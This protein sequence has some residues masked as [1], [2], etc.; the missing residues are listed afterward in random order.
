M[1]YAPHRPSHE[2]RR[3]VA[4]SGCPLRPTPRPASRPAPV[5][6][7]GIT[8]DIS[9]DITAG[10]ACRVSP[11]ASTGGSP[12]VSPEVSR[13]V[14]LGMGRSLFSGITRGVARCRRAVPVCA[15]FAFLL[16]GLL[17]GMVAGPF[18]GMA[19]DALAA[20][21]QGTAPGGPASEQ[22][23]S[24]SGRGDLFTPL[25]PGGGGGMCG[26]SMSPYGQG[27]VVVD[28][29]PTRLIEGAVKNTNYKIVHRLTAPDDQEI[30]A[31]CM[32]LRDD[33]KYIIPALE[34]GNAIIC[35]DEDDAAAW[36]K[37]PAPGQD[38]R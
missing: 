14:S 17:C 21:T 11:D 36:V 27:L 5:M 25:G 28:Q 29:V 10:M 24:G 18:P 30:M 2:D 38:V 23:A 26:P 4:H 3:Q 15:V 6:A 33:Q 12:D 1:M 37:M 20:G 13:G 35:G 16:A 34:K 9:A 32:A 22:G 8:A 31:S 19:G 7:P